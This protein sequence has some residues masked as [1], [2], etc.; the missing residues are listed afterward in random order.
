MRVPRHRREWV[1]VP[2]E[3]SRCRLALKSNAGCCHIHSLCPQVT[4]AQP[5]VT[6]HINRHR[7][8]RLV[9]LGP[10]HWGDKT[11]VQLSLTATVANLTRVLAA[12]R[13]RSAVLLGIS[14]FL[15]SK[16][17]WKATE[18][19]AARV[20]SP[21]SP[22]RPNLT[23]QFLSLSHE[24]DRYGRHGVPRKTA[25]HELLQGRPRIR[26][27][28]HLRRVQEPAQALEQ[29]PGFSRRCV[30]AVYWCFRDNSSS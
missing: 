12:T 2:P 23:L 21:D 22:F 13:S 29:A 4:T 24:A 17:P 7:V 18:P 8:A 3:F 6:E 27:A 30:G 20:E 26:T 5:L 16:P 25:G 9:Q 19:P 10:V 11:A 15:G 28:N 1:H 14:T